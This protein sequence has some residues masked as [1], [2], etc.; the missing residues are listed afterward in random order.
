MVVKS[1]YSYNCILVKKN[2]TL[3][4]LRPLVPDEMTQSNYVTLTETSETYKSEF[5]RHV[6]WTIKSI[7]VIE[8]WARAVGRAGQENMYEFPPP[9]DDVLFFGN[10]L[11][12]FV[13]AA[14]TVAAAAAANAV[15]AKLLIFA[16]GCTSCLTGKGCP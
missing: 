10:C 7:G 14:A 9:L 2:G 13:P 8:L 3:K 5:R 6:A 12:V 15:A 11:L 1:A 4:Q 16:A